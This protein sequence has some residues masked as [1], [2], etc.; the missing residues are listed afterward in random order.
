MIK[1]ASVGDFRLNSLTVGLAKSQTMNFAK[2][3]VLSVRKCAATRKINSKS[4]I[5]LFVF[6][7]AGYSQ[8]LNY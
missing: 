8:N 1:S 4:L 3:H 2:E 5:G 6:R 7:S